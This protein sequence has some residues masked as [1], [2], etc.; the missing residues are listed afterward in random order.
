MGVVHRES[1]V[2]ENRSVVQVNANRF[3]TINLKV[4]SEIFTL[5]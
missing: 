1:R 5:K 4:I 3:T 2:L